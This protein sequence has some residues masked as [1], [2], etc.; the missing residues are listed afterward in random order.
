MKFVIYGVGAIGG[1]LAARLS[2]SGYEVQ[3]IARGQHLKAIN[4]AGLIL[5]TPETK[6]TAKFRCFDDPTQINFDPDDIIFLSMKTQDTQEALERLRVAGVRGQAIVC[7]QN[8][9]ANERFT[10]RHFKNTYG[11]TVM[12]PASYMVSGEVNAFGAPKH[13]ILDI[14]RYPFGLDENVTTIVDALNASGFAAFAHERV[15][16]NKY[17]KLMLNLSNIIGAALGSE[18]RS[19]PFTKLVRAEGEAVL[20]AANLSYTDLGEKNPRRD[21]LMQDKAIEGVERIG[22]SSAQSL[23]RQSG[24]IETAYLNGE[25]VLLGR[26]HNVP[27]PVNAY[28]C[29]LAQ[30]MVNDA[31]PP[32]TI[33]PEKVKKEIAELGQ[34]TPPLH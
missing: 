30:Q 2:L 17:G 9:V 6:E 21:K 11:M 8:G 34:I 18:A 27:V 13:G 14:G 5:R 32:G 26:L 23:A 10:L 19:G 29:D 15:M 31:I 3:G 33:S 20:R 24:S 1:T 7:A 12:L 16:E 4:D 28:F 22:S 25:I